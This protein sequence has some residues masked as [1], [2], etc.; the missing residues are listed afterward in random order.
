[1]DLN[2]KGKLA[3][4]SGA[5]RG[6]GRA[7]AE[8]LG[9]EGCNLVLTSRTAADLDAVKDTVEKQNNVTVRTVAA[10][11]SDSATV[12]RLAQDFPAID[13]LDQQRRRHSRRAT[14]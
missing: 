3:L 14:G 4:I 6:I 9:A 11:L 5:S 8:E 7:V 2:L 1:M 13:I 12:R 10:D